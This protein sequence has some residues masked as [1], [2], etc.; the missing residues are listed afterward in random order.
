MHAALSA[1]AVSQHTQDVSGRTHIMS[2]QQ[3]GCTTPNNISLEA[4]VDLT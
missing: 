4:S 3:L 1:C 2:T